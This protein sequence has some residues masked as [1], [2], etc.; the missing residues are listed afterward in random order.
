MIKRKYYIILLFGAFIFLLQSCSKETT[1]TPNELAKNTDVKTFGGS[2]NESAQS[3]TATQDGG[4]AVLGLTQS[5]D[6]DVVGKNDTSFDYWLLKF[7]VE[8]QLEWQKTYGGTLDDRGQSIIQ[9]NDGGFAI[10]GY[11]KSSDG[12]L[13][14]NQGFDDFWMV[15]TSASGD[16][17]WEKSFGFSGEDNGYSLIQTN[18]GGFLLCGTLDVSASAGQGNSKMITAKNHSGGYYWLIKLNAL[19]EKQWSHYYGGT[20]TDIAYGA[21]ETL[22]GSLIVVGSSDSEDLDITN[23]KGN[24][25]FWIIKVSATGTLIWEKNFGGSNTDEA[26]AI[27]SS[28]DGNFIVVGETRSNDIDVTNNH[29]A[30]DIW[31]IKINASGDLIWEETYGGSGFDSGRSIKKTPDNNYIIAGNSRS[32]DGDLSINYGENDT[33]VIK[34]DNKGNLIAQNTFGGVDLDLAFDAIQLSNNT[35]IT[36]GESSSSDDD[37]IENK[38]LSDLLILITE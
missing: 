15:K 24:Y 8:N 18:D 12:N 6:G 32:S 11:S 27:V 22:D 25:D 13:S 20:F 29:G 33:W 30:A 1:G 23:N 10:I 26:R 28:D 9:T 34:I 21:A 4:F 19:G 37:I 35:V 31:A 17:Q 36:V 14:V 3:I 5:N 38:G 2:L 7:D 16:I